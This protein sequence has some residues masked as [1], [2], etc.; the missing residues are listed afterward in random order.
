MK[1]IH[2]LIGDHTYDFMPQVVWPKWN[3]N[4]ILDLDWYL[5]THVPSCKSFG[6]RCSN[7][8]EYESWKKVK[9]VLM[10][11]GVR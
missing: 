2:V 1:L 8:K 10:L 4:K 9:G 6:S 7:S 3:R 5:Y 11:I